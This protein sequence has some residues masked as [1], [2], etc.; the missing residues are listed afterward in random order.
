[1]YYS[2]LSATAT[3]ASLFIKCA[4]LANSDPALPDRA[5]IANKADMIEAKRIR[6]RALA[7]LL[8]GF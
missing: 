8:R 4:N 7:K 2:K 3:G 5:R 1:M 6:T